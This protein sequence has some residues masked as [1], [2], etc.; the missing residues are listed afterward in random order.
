MIRKSGNRFS[1]KIMLK[2][3]IT[4]ALHLHFDQPRSRFGDGFRQ[5]LDEIVDIGDR[6]ARHAHAPGKGHE[7]EVRAVELEHVERPL[8]RLAGADA[9]ELATQYLVD[10]V[11]EY[12]R[13]DVEALA[14]LSPQRLQRVHGAAVTDHADDLAIGTRHRGAGRDRG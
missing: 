7:V 6:T 1:E 13:D 9:V 11:G 12:N 2:S 8:P 3:N 14:R 10:L 4:V 5:R